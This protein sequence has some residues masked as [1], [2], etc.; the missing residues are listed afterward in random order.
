MLSKSFGGR[1]SGPLVSRFAATQSALMDPE[2][3]RSFVLQAGAGTH[4]L[5]NLPRC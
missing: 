4:G 3:T 2:E 1:T 5:G